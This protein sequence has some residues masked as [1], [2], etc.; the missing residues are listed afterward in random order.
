MSDECTLDEYLDTLPTMH[1]AR[2]ELVALRMERDQFEDGYDTQSLLK[3]AKGRE[4]K[5]LRA[6]LE[7]ERR[8][9][10]RL[11]SRVNASFREIIEGY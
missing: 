11:R 5:E 7:E 1:R 8:V 10:S 4:I 9:S 2:L 6:E 3:E